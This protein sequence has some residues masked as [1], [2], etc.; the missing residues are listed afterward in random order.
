MRGKSL[1]RVLILT[2]L[3][4]LTSARSANSA[5]RIP[6]ASP[7]WKSTAHEAL[8]K[9]PLSFEL[10]RGQANPTV[11]YLARGLSYTTLLSGNE[12][13]I[14]PTGS[15]RDSLRRKG[16]STGVVRIKF[17]G[18]SRQVTPVALDP[19]SGK[20]NYFIG[21]NPDRWHIGIP[22]F[23]R[24]LY[25]SL[26]PGI[27]LVLYGNQ[28]QLEYDLVVAPGADPRVVRLVFEGAETVKLD[29]QGGLVA[30]VDG[31][32]EIRQRLPWI[33]QEAD[34]V[35]K[36]VRGGCV[37][38][39]KR[40]IGYQIDA[41]DRSRP[42]IVDPVMSYSTFLG[43]RG[44]EGPSGIA[45]DAS[46]SFYVT[47]TTSSTNFPT[48]NPIQ[49][50]YRGGDMG[51]SGGGDIF[52]SKF[53]ATGSALVYSTY[54]GGAG[55][56]FGG[57]IAVDASGN[58]YLS[59]E[60]H[61][62]DF[63]LANP[64]QNSLKGAQDVFV[65]KLN[66]SG[67]ALVYSTYL[68]G[69]G[70]ES[71]RS[72]A[73]DSSGA[74]YVGGS[75]DS[76]DFPVTANSAQ[77]SYG[78]AG[79]AFVAK[80][81][82]A[83][84]QIVYASYVGGSGSE[85]RTPV[86]ITVDSAGN[87]FVVGGT[88]STD[89]PTV[90]SL[91]G[92]YAGGV[93]DGFIAKLNA[94]GTAFLYSTYLGGD[95]VDFLT[96]MAIDS[97]GNMYLTGVTDSTNF[98]TVNA[99]QPR[100]AGG[101]VSLGNFVAADAFVTK[102]DPSGSSVVYST[103]FGG[104]GADFA[105]SL[106]V[107]SVGGAY[108][109]G[110]TTS[111][112]FPT[113]E[114]LQQKK[115]FADAFISK[116]DPSGSLAYSTFLGGNDVELATS[117]T[118]DT[119]GNV[120]LTGVTNS[121]DFPT[122]NPAFGTFGGGAPFNFFGGDA[123]VTKIASTAPPAGISSRQFTIANKGGTFLVS[124]GS[125]PATIG[126]ARIRPDGGKTAPAGVAIFGLTQNGVLVSEAGVPASPLIRSGRIY[127]EVSGPV[128]TGL[129]LV[130][131]N[132]GPARIN[133]FFTDATGK[134]FGAGNVVIAS[135]QQIAKFLNEEPFNGGTSVSGTFTFSSDVPVS[136]IALRGFSNQRGDF[137]I[138]TLPV[139]A[140]PADAELPGL[141]PHFA[142]GGGWVT[143]IILVNPT[144]ETISGK[145]NFF[146]QGSATGPGTALEVTID[147]QTASSFSYTLPP[148]SSRRLAT[149][150]STGAVRVGSVRIVPSTNNKMPSGL[151]IF[152]FKN[153][154]VTVAEA[155]VP[156]IRPGK[157][158]RMYAES[159]GPVQTGV[160]VA[161]A[162]PNPAL[163]NFELTTLAG[164]SLGLAGSFTAPGD[165]QVSRFLGEIPGFQSLR[166]PFQGILRISTTSASG[167]SVVGLRGRVNERGDF[168]ITTTPP[169]DEDA[170]PSNADWFF[171]HFADGGGYTTQFI[172]FSG[173]LD[174]ATSGT[175]DFF[176]QSGQALLLNLR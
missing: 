58:V 1:Y 164:D 75:T 98:P 162:S 150:G 12:M 167:I 57:G 60:T 89:F 127:A 22:H 73:V 62:T 174:Q 115:G 108:I 126:W 32:G 38:T 19:H 28:R 70:A 137:L 45:V 47:G 48:V 158:F 64:I 82:P 118:L 8:L 144:D 106:A 160:A 76:S 165:G 129:A 124:R 11:K 59:G 42:L 139:T 56:E 3:L 136:V 109:V 90:N 85:I 69:S 132:D 33:Y 103:Y 55:A 156:G 134:D 154:N 25:K 41:Y 30:R 113:R 35:R 155:G 133:F 68:G 36:S 51:A 71:T 110:I 143:Q 63:P 31:Y 17:V 66:A 131:P 114:P 21:N 128:N 78:G 93:S 172:L 169:I 79:D 104:A 175:L 145:V 52:I 87:A 18:A 86:A 105:S 122:V 46:G 157:T 39:G 111:T 72:V 20:S 96:W 142:D 77:R 161:N 102:L 34:G 13:I 176:T 123:F 9:L 54:L 170:P 53:N 5:E 4:L 141:F 6:P 67:S 99:H 173:S 95:G 29:S 97:A 168:L 130:N 117:V 49:N 10:N 43:G 149:S 24:V 94:A 16:G 147:S 84:T 44:L 40:E 125:G 119:A 83:G 171:P 23:G 116:F 152:S 159:A 74:V 135:R 151:G 101:S 166:P 61:S 112:D 138:T 120:Y 50:S 14:V 15:A 88:T 7:P 2:T 65:A 92:K 140:L 37:M 27:D 146:G 100:F 163:V 153:A 107:D 26:Y 148:R 80:L 81:N 121:S 91:Q